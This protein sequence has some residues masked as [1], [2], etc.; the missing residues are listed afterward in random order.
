MSPWVGLYLIHT[1]ARLN[2]PRHTKLRDI[3]F[4]FQIGVPDAQLDVLWDGIADTEAAQLEYSDI[5]QLL[6]NRWL[7]ADVDAALTASAPRAEIRHSPTS[8]ARLEFALV[9][10]SVERCR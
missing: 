1:R 5:S 9:W 2:F 6:Q 10:P 7:A 8:D 4:W 3:I